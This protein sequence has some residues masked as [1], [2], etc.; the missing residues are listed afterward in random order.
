MYYYNHD[1]YGGQPPPALSR[2]AVWPF[3]EPWYQDSDTGFPIGQHALRWGSPGIRNYVPRHNAHGHQA[4]KQRLLTAQAQGKQPVRIICQR[5]LSP[6]FAVPAATSAMAAL[7]A[8]HQ[9]RLLGDLLARFQILDEACVS[10]LEHGFHTESCLRLW[11][12]LHRSYTDRIV[13]VLQTME[14]NAEAQRL[15]YR[16]GFSRK[17]ENWWTT[18]TIKPQLKASHLLAPRKTMEDRKR[19]EQVTDLIRELTTAVV[20]ALPRVEEAATKA[21]EG[22]KATIRE[23]FEI[24]GPLES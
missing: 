8:M 12:V 7:S 4:M 15:L 19:R 14:G 17:V 5:R 2:H 11:R 9:L 21:A 3:D 13:A 24:F 23:A 6:D 22:M 18:D 20:Q 16:C 1:A 10:S